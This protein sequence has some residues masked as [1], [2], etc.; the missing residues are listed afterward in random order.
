M[1]LPARQGSRTRKERPLRLKPSAG[2]FMLVLSLTA[3]AARADAPPEA[4]AVLAVEQRWLKAIEHGDVKWM[5]ATL[6]EN[7][8]HVDYTGKLYYR[9]DELR[10]S[11]KPSP[12]AEKWTGQTVDFAGNAAVVH[13]VS[14]V[15]D[16]GKVILRQRYTD[17]YM[18]ANGRWI[19]LSAQET[20][21]KG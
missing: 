7:Y 9:E 12:Y 1:L 4:Q 2:F 5:A 17:V 11:A 6:P 15:S 13:G 21:I 16:R 18:K 3:G 20:A 8:V 14:T 19:P 10:A